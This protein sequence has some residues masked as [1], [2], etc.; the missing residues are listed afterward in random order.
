MYLLTCSSVRA[1]MKKNV[2]VRGLYF[3]GKCKLELFEGHAKVCAGV[4]VE[5]V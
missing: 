3:C 1:E 2:R 5:G 4:P